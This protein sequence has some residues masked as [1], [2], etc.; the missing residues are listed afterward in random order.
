M[1]IPSQ[2]TVTRPCIGLGRLG[3][4]LGRSKVSLGYVW[5]RI[6]ILSL[7][8]DTFLHKNSEKH[9]VTQGFG[10]GFGAVQRLDG[11]IASICG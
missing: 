5:D 11:H 7:M 9:F 8:L 3:L 2:L 1:S 6:G 10:V 4:G